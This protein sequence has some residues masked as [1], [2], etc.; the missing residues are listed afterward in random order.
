MSELIL[1]HGLAGVPFFF[2]EAG[3]NV[4]SIEELS[5]LIAENIYTIGSSFIS[6]DLTDWIG[7]ELGDEKL[8]RDLESLIDSKAPLHIFINHILS[9]NALFSEDE[10]DSLSK[11]SQSVENLGEYECVKMRADRMFD[12]GRLEDSLYEYLS[13]IRNKDRYDLNSEQSGRIYHN[14][15]CI[16]MRLFMTD[17]ASRSFDTAYR[18]GRD[19]ESLKMLLLIWLCTDNREKFNDVVEKY[20]IKPSFVNSVIDYYNSEKD[21]ITRKEFDKTGAGR[22]ISHWKKE[23]IRSSRM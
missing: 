4:Y 1:C 5:Y 8:K 21:K 11:I 18:M 17:E 12:E 7:S 16:Y 22:K 9:S 14:M 10:I 19:P 6:H 2:E 13:I 23:Y 3:K 15:G 20:L